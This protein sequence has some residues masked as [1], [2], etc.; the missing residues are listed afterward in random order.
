M[1]ADLCPATWIG[2]AGVTVDL[3]CYK[4]ADHEPPHEDITT[5][6]EWSS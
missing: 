3:S 2:T 6:E 5:G 1:P 4:V